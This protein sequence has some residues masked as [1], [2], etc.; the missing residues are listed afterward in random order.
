MHINLN[1]LSNVK[2]NLLGSFTVPTNGWVPYTVSDDLTKYNII[3]VM[4]STTDQGSYPLFMTMDDF[5]NINAQ[6]A[7]IIYGTDN[8]DRI[9][10]SYSSSTAI[11]IYN[12]HTECTLIIRGFM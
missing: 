11:G 8:A 3:S 2:G 10:V 9:M 5:I 7:V 4:V 6:N 12:T 1:P